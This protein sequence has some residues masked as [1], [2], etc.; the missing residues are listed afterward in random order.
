MATSSASA[1]LKPPFVRLSTRNPSSLEISKT[2][3]GG[4]GSTPCACQNSVQ[5]SERMGASGRPGATAEDDGAAGTS[6][7]I[8]GDGR[9]GEAHPATAIAATSLQ[10]HDVLRTASASIATA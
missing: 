8:G 3:T 7:A 10:S 5:A 2:S 1:S 6:T 9:G 4:A